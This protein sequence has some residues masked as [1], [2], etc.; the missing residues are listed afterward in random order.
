MKSKTLLRIAFFLTLITS[1]LSS[2]GC[3]SASE[4]ESGKENITQLSVG[5]TS[6]QVFFKL[7]SRLTQGLH[8]GERWV[9]PPTYEIVVTD[10][11]PYTVEARVE[12]LDQNGLPLFVDPEWIVE[13]PEMVIVSPGQNNAVMIIIQSDGQST[14]RIIT[15]DVTKTLSVKAIYKNKALLVEV[16]QADG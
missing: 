13:N 16:S 6:I 15:P 3:A 14:L 1:L 8:M 7:D 12:I 4:N 2:I 11:V 9:S 5:P 10:G